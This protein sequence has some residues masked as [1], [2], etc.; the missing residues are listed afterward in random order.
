MSKWQWGNRVIKDQIKTLLTKD[1]N[2]VA[3]MIE[4]ILVVYINES[5]YR[6]S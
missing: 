3:S 5:I 2:Q 4:G 1:L 6:F